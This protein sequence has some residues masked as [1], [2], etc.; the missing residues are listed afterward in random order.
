M[1]KI[2]ILKYILG[3][4]MF[5]ERVCFVF[6]NI[7]QKSGIQNLSCISRPHLNVAC[8]IMT[9]NKWKAARNSII[10]ECKV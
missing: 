5:M 9:Q 1:L 4:L 2:L 6:S 7:G 10:A 8:Y 3:T